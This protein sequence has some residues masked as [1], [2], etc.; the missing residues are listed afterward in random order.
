M[1]RVLHVIP[2]LGPLRGG[3]SFA[4]PIL[5]QSLARQEVEVHVATT[6]DNGPGRLPSA[7]GRAVSPDGVTTWYFPR[8]TRFYTFS[9]PLTAWLARHAGEF[10]LLHI[11][12]L[13]SYPTAAASL[14]A[15]RHGVPYIVRP[16][17]TLNQWGMTQ[18]RPRLKQLSFQLVERR[19][20]KGAAAIHYT[21]EQE[22]LE[23]EQLG[24]FGPA[25]VIPLGIDLREFEQPAP[26]AAFLHAHPSLAGRPIIL[27]LSRL[28]PKKGLDLLLPAFAQL[29]QAQPR[30]ALVLAGEGE[31]EFVTALRETADDL[32]IGDSV[33]FT[34]FLGGQEKLSA[35]AAATAFVLPSYSEN[36]GVAPV[37]AMAAGLPVV[38]SEHVA[39]SGDVRK[40]EAGLVVPV[41]AGA[42]AAAMERLLDPALCSRLGQN[43]R[44]LARTRFT[45]DAAARELISLYHEVRRHDARHVA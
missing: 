11:H 16:L 31:P 29:R 5:A 35:L 26:P 12:A 21:S 39:I 36:F 30:A 10:D 38:L 27:F 23:A 43:A 3:P 17:G 33:V 19:I 1:V 6:D 25:A 4:L 13:F 40:A 41:E 34:R 28:D 44:R 42:L 22:R 45:A 18:R 15:A 24:R 2:S 7:S 37:E 20:L 14:A 9:W 8:Q 32:G